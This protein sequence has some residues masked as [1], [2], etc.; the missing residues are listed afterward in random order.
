MAVDFVVAAAWGFAVL[1]L[2]VGLFQLALALGAPWGALAWGGQ[3]KGTLPAGYRWG[4]AAS[5]LMYSFFALVVLERARVVD[6]LPDAVSNV[7]IWVVVGFLGLGVIMNGISRSRPERFVMTPIVLVLTLLALLVALG[8]G[9]R[10]FA[11][12]VID[13]GSGASLC[14]VVLTSYPPQCG[15]PVSVEGWDWGAVEHEREGS[16]RWGDYTFTGVEAEGAIT[17]TAVP[18]PRG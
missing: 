2:L 11:G 3:H 10:V 6:L 16:V 14:T 17:I 15:D 9:E 5:I 1:M 13:D 12:T 4:S 7:V 8:G 18:T